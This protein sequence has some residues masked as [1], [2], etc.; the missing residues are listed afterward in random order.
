MFCMASVEYRMPTPILVGVI[1]LSNHWP[2]GSSL[3][4]VH[5]KH[6]DPTRVLAQIGAWCA[7]IKY[8]ILTISQI[9]V[10]ADY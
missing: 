1:A 2:V 7:L 5:S 10:Q 8:V 4:D 3:D 9:R 6:G